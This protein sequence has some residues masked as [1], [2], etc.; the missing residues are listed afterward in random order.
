MNNTA[1]LHDLKILCDYN[2]YDFKW[3]NS[4]NYIKIIVTIPDTQE[5]LIEVGKG[6]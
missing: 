2:K 4:T 1:T 3:E 5:E 6:E